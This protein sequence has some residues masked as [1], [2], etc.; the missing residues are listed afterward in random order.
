LG[1]TT[2]VLPPGST[3]ANEA[4]SIATEIFKGSSAL[5][6]HRQAAAHAMQSTET[7]MR[8]LASLQ[9]VAGIDLVR[10]IGRDGPASAVSLHTVSQM[11]AAQ[12]NSIVRSTPIAPAAEAFFTAK[13][14]SGTG[15]AQ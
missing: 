5:S 4:L 14:A 2:S 7:S 15:N 11:N 9:L 12:A 3:F 10:V 1:A 8:L 13:A 6:E